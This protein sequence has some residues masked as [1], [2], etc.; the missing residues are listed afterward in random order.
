M[1]HN[2]SISVVINVKHNKQNQAC[3]EFLTSPIYNYCTYLCSR[4]SCVLRNADKLL[5]APVEEFVV[6]SVLL[7]L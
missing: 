1:N 5:I 3:L 4:P 2:V 7:D 6:I